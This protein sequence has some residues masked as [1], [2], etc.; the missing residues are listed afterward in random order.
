MNIV[1]KD[2]MCGILT[3]AVSGRGVCLRGIRV[4]PASYLCKITLYYGARSRA[5]E[6]RCNKVHFVLKLKCKMT[7]VNRM[8]GC[9]V[10]GNHPVRK[11]EV[12]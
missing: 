4:L 5:A 11:I 6:L 9:V 3:T 10:R 12:A 2:F 7:L 1:R 8:V